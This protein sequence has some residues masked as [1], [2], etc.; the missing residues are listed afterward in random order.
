MGF[1]KRLLADHEEMVLDLRPHW[2]ALVGPALLAAVV[3]VGGAFALFNLPDR[4][5]SW[6]RWAI[7]A[8]GVALLLFVALRELLTWLTSH[9][10]V[11]TERIIHRSGWLAKRS[12]EI[13]LD[14]INDVSFHQ[15][16]FERMV[17]AGDLIIE[18]GGEF[19]QNRFSD[20]RKPENVQK[21]IF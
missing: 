20:I 2:V 21:T 9:F 5:P 16:V 17:G 1:P 8:A 3:V 19:G 13:P 15:T 4:W 18:S 14:R 7:L 12:M 11:T 10:V 6:I